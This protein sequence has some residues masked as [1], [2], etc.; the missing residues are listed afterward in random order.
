MS[1]T[2][3]HAFVGDHAHDSMISFHSALTIIEGELY[4]VACCWDDNSHVSI[5]PHTIL[6]I[7]GGELCIEHAGGVII[8]IILS[9]PSILLCKS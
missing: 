3:Q 8:L 7:I 2:L 9:T 4:I 6:E 5:S 1:S